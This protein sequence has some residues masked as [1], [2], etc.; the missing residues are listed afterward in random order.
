MQDTRPRIRYTLLA[1]AVF[2][3]IAAAVFVSSV[4]ERAPWFGEAPMNIAGWMT[5]G[6][7]QMAR[8]WYREG[9]WAMRFAM[10]W[11][12]ASIEQPYLGKRT[13]YVSYPP[14]AIL[15]LYVAAL[16]LGREPTPGLAMSL[17][18]ALH[19]ATALLLAGATALLLRGAAFSRGTTL[20]SA[21]IPFLLYVYLPI[22]YH[23][24][25]MSY[26]ADAA[27]L[28]L[29]ALFVFLEIALEQTSN[30]RVRRCIA[31]LQASVGLIGV[32][33]D[34]LFVFL[35][36]CVWLGRAARGRLG[37]GV[38]RKVGNT[39]L[40][41][42]PFVAGVTLFVAQVAYL[43]NMDTLLE[44][45]LM[46]S[47]VTS[48]QGFADG[49]NPLDFASMDTFLSFSLGT[50]FW[51][52][53]IPASFGAH[54]V[55]IIVGCLAA[56][57]VLTVL[58]MCVALGRRWLT[59]GTVVEGVSST[60]TIRNTSVGAILAACF[61][62][63]VPCLLYYH[64]FKQ[65]NNLLFH[66]Y[67]ALKFALPIATL[68]LALLPAACWRMWF[69]ANTPLP[70]LIRLAGRLAPQMLLICALGFLV[71]LSP[72]RRALFASDDDLRH[73]A[74]GKFIGQNT[75]HNDILFAPA[76]PPWA[77]MPQF[78][79]YAMKRLHPADSIWKLYSFLRG[80]DGPW[81]VTVY[82]DRPDRLERLPEMQVL[83]SSADM[84][85]AQGPMSLLFIDKARFLMLCNALRVGE[86]HPDDQNGDRRLDDVE[87]A[88][89]ID[90][91]QRGAEVGGVETIPKSFPHPADYGPGVS[92][93]RMSLSEL[94]RQFQLSNSGGYHLDANAEGRFAPGLE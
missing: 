56:W 57:L 36:F 42:T 43:G 22:A 13:P 67:S 25:A 6:S 90:A 2:M 52:E 54:G 1:L 70:R 40:F 44:R 18:L 84:A 3:V 28:P 29:Y 74:S 50:R 82:L 21:L 41:G 87:L 55:E 27:A 91:Y 88:P 51:K 61:L 65:H 69:A 72:E 8:N 92:D 76:P 37:R 47:G 23:E 39:L 35:A 19:C 75:A 86:R 7:T 83:T 20:V 24:H 68:P 49:R 15:P 71:S 34:W 93:G 48:G 73:V 85:V 80:I 77:D 58:A 46:R 62:Y 60:N 79:C 81:R 14:G 30:V 63:L 89:L 4:V 32:L 78:Q 66:R 12:P 31:V 45:F 53:H 64:V 38:R 10:Y 17:S 11:E 9:A 26:F 94:L 5:G 59:W 16:L 33:T